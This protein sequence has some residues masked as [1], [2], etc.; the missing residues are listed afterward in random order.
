MQRTRSLRLGD[1]WFVVSELWWERVVESGGGAP[2]SDS[3]S[4]GSDWT[5]A[6]RVQN[7]H[8]VDRTRSCR[9]CSSSALKPGLVWCWLLLSTGGGY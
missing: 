8:L 2:A 6:W 3:D 4:D 5:L 7:N 1:K 9:C